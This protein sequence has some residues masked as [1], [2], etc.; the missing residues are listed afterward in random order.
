[1]SDLKNRIQQWEEGDAYITTTLAEIKEEY[2][3]TQAFLNNDKERNS[4]LKAGADLVFRISPA[5]AN[6]A[7]GDKR[8]LR[9]LLRSEELTIR[10]N[11]SDRAGVGTIVYQDLIDI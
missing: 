9:D 7:D 6:R 8:K 1:M 10:P 3:I 4:A 5:Y 11:T 2:E